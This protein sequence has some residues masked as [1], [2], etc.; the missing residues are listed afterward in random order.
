MVWLSTVVRRFL[1][2]QDCGEINPAMGSLGPTHQGTVG[3]P[4]SRQKKRHKRE[5]S[6]GAER[7]RE[8][9][10]WLQESLTRG[11][12]RSISEMRREADFAVD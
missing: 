8:R 9:P 12:V 7:R 1:Q 5:H 2:R 6:V 11:L 10:P 4:K 3:S